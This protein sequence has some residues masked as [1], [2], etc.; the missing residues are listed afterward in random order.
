MPS[1]GVVEIFTLMALEKPQ[2]LPEKPKTV[3]LNTGIFWKP[4]ASPVIATLRY[5][6]DSGITFD[7]KGE[8]FH[9]LAKVCNFH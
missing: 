6:N 5:Y 9:V 8:L 2:T 4:G 1:T 7:T 3:I